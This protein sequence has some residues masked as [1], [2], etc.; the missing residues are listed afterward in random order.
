MTWFGDLVDALLPRAEVSTQAKQVSSSVVYEQ[1]HP[2]PHHDTIVLSNYRTASIRALVQAAKFADDTE[3]A[4]KLAQLLERWL[5][6][7]STTYEIIPMP[8]APRR[9]RERGYNQVSRIAAIATKNSSHRLQPQLLQR[10]RDTAP[11]TSLP[12]AQRQRNVAEAFTVSTPTTE[13]TNTH[14][15]LLDDVTTTGATM[16]AARTALATLSPA[17]I[18]CLAIA[19]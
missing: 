5:S 3:A 14:L 12:K 13:Y 18:T 2:R 6:E 9:F 11:Q 15:L 4:A 7:Q 19:G 1:Y 10:T 8:L 16:H 17:S